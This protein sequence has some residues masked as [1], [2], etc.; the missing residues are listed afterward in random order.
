MKIEIVNSKSNIDCFFCKNLKTSLKEC[1]KKIKIAVVGEKTSLTLRDLDIE[2]DFVP[3]ELHRP[4]MTLHEIV[5]LDEELQ[6]NPTRA[7]LLTGL[8]TS[9]QSNMNLITAHMEL[10]AGKMGQQLLVQLS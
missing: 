7:S 10:A 4:P 3:P 6:V 9:P 2:A 5:D 1:S 8:P